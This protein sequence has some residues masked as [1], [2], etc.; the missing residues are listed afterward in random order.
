[1]PV[2]KWVQESFVILLVWKVF[3]RSFG[4]HSLKHLVENHADTLGFRSAW[5]TLPVAQHSQIGQHSK[6]RWAA[7]IIAQF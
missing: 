2:I 7:R 6:D 1:M 4:E 5:V 3:V